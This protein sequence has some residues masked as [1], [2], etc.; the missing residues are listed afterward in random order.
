MRLLQSRA[1][2]ITLLFLSLTFNLFAQTGGKAKITGVLKDAKTQETIPFATAV[3]IDK[4]TAKNVK[5]AQTDLN[6]A[7][8]MTDLPKGNFTFKISF[9][10][11]QTMVRDNVAI[12]AA[13]GTLNFGDIKMNAAKGNI[14]SEVTVTGQKQGM[15]M[16]IDKKIFSVDQSVISEGGSATDLLQNV[17]SVSTDMDGNVSLRGSTGVKVLIDGKPSLIAGGNVAQILASIPASSIESVE[18]ITN[19]SAKYDAEGQSGIINIVLKKNTKLG[20]N[21]SA[22]ITA[23]NRDNYNANTNLSFQNSKVNIYGN[24]SYRYGNRVGGGYQDITYKSDSARTAF[25]NQAT[26]SN[27]LEKGHNAKAGLDYYLAPK[28]VISLSGGFNSRENERNELLDIRQ[29]N[30]AQTPVS[31]S[32][33]TNLNDGYGSSY[34]LNLDYV[35]KFK[36]PKEELS[37]NFGYS[38][39]DNNNDQ[40][41]STTT[42]N[43]NNV[44]INENLS[45]QRVFNR[46]DNS[47][48]NIQT[49]YS[50]PVGKAGKVEVGYRSQIRLG[51]NNQYADSILTNTSVYIENN[52][53]IN[54]FNSKDQVHALY[55]NYQNQIKDFGYQLGLRAEDARLDTHLDGYTNNVLTSSEGNIHYKRLYPSVFLTQKLKGDNQLQLSYTRRVNRPRPW[56]TNPFL[57]V[58]DPF[59]YRGGNPNLLPEDVHSFELGYSKYWKKVTLTSSLYFRQT[60]DVIQRVRSSP[61]NGIITSTPQNLSRQINSGLELIGRFDLVK[62]L[63]FTTNVNLYQAK[64]DGDERFNIK[65]SKGF[66]WNGNVTANLTVVKNVSVQVRGDYRA[67]EVMA[68]GKRNAMYGI[69]GGAKYDFPNKKASLSFNVRDVFNTRRWS[70]TTED[71]FTIVDF[72]RQMQGTMGNLTFS[73]R[74]GKT[75]FSNVKKQKKEDQQEN[76]PDE[77]SF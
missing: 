64:F 6:G 49:D 77:G 23:G 29:L 30:R 8:V 10:G 67:P 47:N 18:V 15:Q 41:Y 56:D 2:P 46:G 19:P 59:N 3:L 36:K 37:F 65:S 38:S 39:G 24:Y 69:D 32:N 20:F 12:T 60:N 16:G 35:Q 57:D 48:Y 74:F 33:R 25:T 75:T 45:L 1:V 50:L 42:T 21:G 51:D 26:T 4:T 22:A 71:D 28:S 14:L 13:T 53:L 72:E 34:D 54:N 43:R 17:P 40:T 63:N 9:V 11:Y 7:F 52:K 61:V 55:V 27:T 70:M 68:Q 73:Y 31:L 62:A 44:P 5:I 58:S 76:R 66:S